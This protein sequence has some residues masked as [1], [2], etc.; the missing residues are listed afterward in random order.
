[1]SFTIVD[2]TP[3]TTEWLAERL[4]SIGAS[5]AAGVLG[6][7]K[8]QSP[9]SVFYSKMG[10]ASDFP[11]ELSYVTHASEDVVA[12]WV[13][14]FHP[15]WGILEPGFMA[16]SVTAP[17]L[18]ASFD[19]ILLQP[20]GTRIPLQIK[21]GHQ[22]AM[23][24]WDA[25]VPVEYQ[26]Q[27]QVEMFVYGAQKARLVVMHGGRTFDWFDIIR[28]DTF[29]NDELIPETRAFWADHV[30]QQLPP[31]PVTT[32]EA[33]QVWAGDPELSVE[34]SEALFDLWGAYGLM[35]AEEIS[36][37]EAIEAV[38][39]QLQLAMR[40]ATELTYLGQTLFTW[41]PRKGASRFDAAGFKAAHPEMVPEFT[42]VGA[43][44]R[45]FVRKT[46]KEVSL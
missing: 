9:L 22:N 21:T 11:E 26:V 20:D 37:K 15:E 45:T 17:W 13:T 8:Y 38:K 32:A 44:T 31:E 27:E 28:D 42:T 30:S 23:S 24:S 16:R 46:V 43:P 2:I 35:Q 10:Q 25:G 41:K 19:R 40:D 14:K 4:N 3:D 33:A 5:E 36:A 29:I 12:G 39:L 34:G 6:R 1:M 7:S 18:H